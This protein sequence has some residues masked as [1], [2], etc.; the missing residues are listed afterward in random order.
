VYKRSTKANSSSSSITF[1]LKAVQGTEASRFFVERGFELMSSVSA[2]FPPHLADAFPKKDDN[3]LKGYLE[4][5]EERFASEVKDGEEFCF[6][7]DQEGDKPPPMD[8]K[9]L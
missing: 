4:D 3:T 7:D 2:S 5:D 9:N 6:E 8:D 1:Y